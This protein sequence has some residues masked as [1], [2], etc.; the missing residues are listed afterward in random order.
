MLF[1][2]KYLFLFATL[3]ATKECSLAANFTCA[4]G[5]HIVVARGSLEPQG[6]GIMGAVANQVLSR[7]P[8]S[9]ISSLIYPAIFD[10]YRPSQTAGVSNLAKVVRH[11]ATVCPKTKIVLLGYSQVSQKETFIYTSIRLAMFGMLTQCKQGAHVIADVMCGAS[12]I[13]FPA[14]KP[15][16]PNFTSKSQLK[17]NAEVLMY[18]LP[19]L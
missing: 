1:I 12:S 15:L 17:Q 7:I 5:A 3:V 8:N 9:D 13:G 11:Y 6:P 16:P 19:I 2:L 14:I 10:P 4:S 18:F